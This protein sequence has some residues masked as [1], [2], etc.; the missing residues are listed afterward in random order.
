MALEYVTNPTYQYKLNRSITE[1]SINDQDLNNYFKLK[2]EYFNFIKDLNRGKK[3][4]KI[5]IITN[6]D[7]GSD[8]FKTN[9]PLEFIEGNGFF[10]LNVL[11]DQDRSKIYSKTIHVNRELNVQNRI[12][13]IISVIN[14]FNLNVKKQLLNNQ[15]EIIR[16]TEST[17]KVLYEN[18]LIETLDYSKFLEDIATDK[19]NFKKDLDELKLK[20]KNLYVELSLLK[21]LLFSKIENSE[22]IANQYILDQHILL[23][24]LNEIFEKTIRDIDESSNTKLNLN[25]YHKLERLI[26]QSDKLYKGDL[27]IVKGSSNNNEI[28]IIYNLVD[29]NNYLIKIQDEVITVEID[30]L[31]PVKGIHQLV[32]SITYND[33]LYSINYSDY[34]QLMKKNGIEIDDIK[35]D[36]VINNTIGKKGITKPDVNYISDNKKII[37]KRSIKIKKSKEKPLIINKLKINIIDQVKLYDDK[38]DVFMFYTMSSD[39]TPGLGKREKLVGK[40]KYQNLD[41]IQDW[42]RK[43]SNFWIIKNMNGSVVP[44]II[45]NLRFSTVEHYYNFSKFWNI[46]YFSGQ[47]RKQYNTYA[48]KFTYDYDGTDSWGRQSAE[49]AKLKGSIE[50]GYQFR[51]DWFKP[52]KGISKNILKQL[53]LGGGDNINM[54]DY[55][56]LKGIYAKF[57]QN[58]ELTNILKYSQDALL[59]HPKDESLKNNINEIAFHHLYVRYLIKNEKPL[60]M[61]DNKDKDSILAEKQEL[62]IEKPATGDTKD[63][64]IEDTELESQYNTMK[65]KLKTAGIDAENMSNK[66]ILDN[67]NKLAKKES[68]INKKQLEI[69]IE[70]LNE[71]IIDNYGK[72]IYSVPADGDCGYYSIVEMLAEKNIF[73]MNHNDGEED[74]QYSSEQEL[75]DVSIT[76][77]EIKAMIHKK[78]M[79]ELRRDIANK[80]KDNIKVDE[81]QSDSLE[82]VKQ[83]I[84]NNSGEESYTKLV[85]DKQ[86]QDIY[87]SY[88]NDGTK[89]DWISELELIIASALFNLNINIYLSNNNIITYNAAESSK[90][91]PNGIKYNLGS[92]PKTIELGLYSGY[93]YV[94]ILDRVEELSK[95]NISKKIEYYVTNILI[96][97]KQNY[98]VAFDYDDDEIIPLGI[99]EKES[100]IIKYFKYEDDSPDEDIE[101]VLQKKL[102][103]LSLDYINKSPEFLKITYYIDESTKLVYKN[104]GITEESIGYLEIIKDSDEEE[105]TQIIFT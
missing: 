59:I 77:E 99:Y 68:L 40:A 45:D 11:D 39:S 28:G 81:K 97:N 58:T 104:S 5:F 70:K 37:K 74:G 55:I 50:S 98:N 94:G 82:I 89:G 72:S 103:D 53:Q 66:E 42:R 57:T 21:D 8:T 48:M 86:I 15:L 105:F 26:N 88:T 60:I 13:S 65:K 76:N 32:K 67:I 84:Y 23:S 78:A 101:I 2:N 30:N 10:T 87:Y 16:R 83:S 29:E 34:V 69:E 80:F 85:H 22:R 90:I 14:N 79:I 1:K 6:T 100:Q 7:S 41:N 9:L 47:K 92:D 54:A 17:N 71:V 61:Y 12:N 3:K 102:E 27:V 95:S 44:I 36:V 43:L 62:I 18:K 73:P 64:T 38:S 35:T 51:N 93:H 52:V 24:E 49:I 33:D 19:E 75:M 96:A 91:Y 25:D 46:P 20:T 56:L 63:S 31:V 4:K